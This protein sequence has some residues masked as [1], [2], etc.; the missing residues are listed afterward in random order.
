MRVDFP[1]FAALVTERSQIV[2]GDGVPRLAVEGVADGEVVAR[3]LSPGPL[4]A[5][6]GVNVT[7]ARPEL[8]A[9]T[10]KDIADLDARGRAGRRLRRALVR[11]HGRRPRA[12][13]RRLG[14]LPAGRG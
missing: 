11:A 8:P 5:R 12:A 13:A 7:Y 4:S 6:K 9:I 10:E 14:A 1:D 3:V 2:I